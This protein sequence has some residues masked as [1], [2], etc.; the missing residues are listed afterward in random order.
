MIVQVTKAYYELVFAK[1]SLDGMF[2]LK[3]SEARWLKQVEQ[4]IAVQAATTTEL[5]AAQSTYNQVCYQVAYSEQSYAKAR[6]ELEKAMYTENINVD[7]VNTH[8]QRKNLDITLAECLDL[9][10]QNRVELKVLD[11]T[12]KAAKFTQDIIRSEEMPNVS[13]VGTYG[14]S[15]EAFSERDLNL[16]TEWSLMGKVKWFLGGKSIESYY[17][18][19]KIS[20]YKV[21]KTDTNVDTQTLN[22]KF[23]FWDNLAHF[24]K[25]KE[26]QI[27]RTQ[28]LKD[29]EEMKNKIRQETEEAYFSF[30]KY[31]TQLALAINEIGYRRKQLEIVKTKRLINDGTVPDIM[32]AELQLEQANA[33]LQEALAGVNV[34]IV[35]LNRAV[36][37]INYFQ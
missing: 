8:L 31:K 13:M 35:T 14:R 3:E 7:M 36:G 25:Q 6:L 23:A 24:T 18:K 27:S 26:A 21:V 11:N 1:N 20:P 5:L 12:I 33:H 34:S 17:K 29:L 2:R 30:K 37:V 28:A 4:E 9:A 19:E 15:G 32:D 10:F 16:A 22:A